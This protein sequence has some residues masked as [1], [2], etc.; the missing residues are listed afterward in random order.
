MK[1]VNFRMI[2]KEF[3]N[4]LLWD[5]KYKDKHSN[6]EITYIHRGAPGDI[7]Y[8]NFSEIHKI[9][10]RFLQGQRGHS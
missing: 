10:L 7:K 4:Q 9:A 8:V 1:K 6:F 3:F 5:D 2:L